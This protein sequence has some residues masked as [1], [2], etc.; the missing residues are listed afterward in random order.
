MHN[1]SYPRVDGN[2]RSRRASSVQLR[3]ARVL[4]QAN[5]AGGRALPVIAARYGL[6][7]S[8]SN[9]ATRSIS[10]R[11]ADFPSEIVLIRDKDR[12]AFVTNDSRT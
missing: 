12:A 5:V 6:K 3:C 8:V 11:V 7:D 1:T 10:S 4:V 9:S 2:C